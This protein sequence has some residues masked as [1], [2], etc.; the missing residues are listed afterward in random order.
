MAS[1]PSWHVPLPLCPSPLHTASSRLCLSF[2]LHTV[3]SFGSFRLSMENARTWRGCKGGQSE[4]PPQGPAPPANAP[5]KGDTAE[6]EED[7]SP[8]L[9]CSSWVLTGTEAGALS[10]RHGW[11]EGGKEGQGSSKSPALPQTPGTDL[12]SSAPPAHSR[13]CLTQQQG[14]HQ[15]RAVRRSNAPHTGDVDPASQ[16]SQEAAQHHALTVP[17]TF[18]FLEAKNQQQH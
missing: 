11:E 2:S 4:K 5:C 18:H 17:H 14:L 8:G 15:Q 16:S 13:S 1:H 6:E 7:S 3:S 12:Q 10:T 9:L